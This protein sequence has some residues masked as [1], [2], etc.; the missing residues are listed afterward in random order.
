[1][2]DDWRR[3]ALCAQ[4]DP[5]LFFP[6]SGESVQPAKKVCAQCP[7]TAE[8]LEYSLAHHERY[9]VWGGTSADQRRELARRTRRQAS[10]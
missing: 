8:C 4:V 6:E 9:G 7:V 2:P 1:M 5:V 10:A 3:D